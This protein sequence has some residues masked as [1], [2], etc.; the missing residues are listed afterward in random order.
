MLH[1]KLGAY[2]AEKKYDVTEAEVLSA[3]R[4]HT[5][6]KPGMSLLEKIIYIADYIEPRRDK[7]PHLKAVRQ[8]AFQDLDR[9]LLMILEDTVQY[10]DASAG[11]TDDMTRKTYEYYKELL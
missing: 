5:T 3:I 1:A 9:A 7:A 8:M 11:D 6:G 2:L 10:L 4:W